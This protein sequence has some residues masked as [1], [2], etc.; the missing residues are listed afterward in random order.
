MTKSTQQAPVAC[1]PSAQI[2]EGHV[3]VAECAEA[4][5]GG[6]EGYR[7]RYAIEV[8]LAFH[9][10]QEQPPHPVFRC[11]VRDVEYAHFAISGWRW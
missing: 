6:V 4:G 11:A 2:M 3:E 9:Q 5:S 8:A 7:R 10:L 1:G